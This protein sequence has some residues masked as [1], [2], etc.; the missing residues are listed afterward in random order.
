MYS[1]CFC[2]FVL[3]S[4]S[5]NEYGNPERIAADIAKLK[6]VESVDICTG[7]WEIVLKVRVKDQDEYYNLIKNVVSRKGIEK[8]KSLL[9]MKQLKTEFVEV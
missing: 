9:S 4:L 7:D 8:I 3:I 1:G 6:E 2:T 5:P